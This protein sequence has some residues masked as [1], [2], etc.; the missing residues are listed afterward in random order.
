MRTIA[1]PILLL[2][3]ILLAVFATAALGLNLYLQS[4]G[5]RTLL[6]RELSGM[7][8][9][10]VSIH[11]ILGLPVLGIRLN[12]VTAGEDP[13]HPFLSVESITLHPDYLNLL[14]GRLVIEKIQLN[15][16]VV[17]LTLGKNPEIPSSTAVGS[18]GTVA[19]SI[20]SVGE[21]PPPSAP[22]SSPS[23]TIHSQA[24]SPY[25]DFLRS[26]SISNGEFT[27]L[28]ENGTRAISLTGIDLNA[29]PHPIEG[30][31]GT[32]QATQSVLADHLIIH[33]ISSSLRLSR[34]FSKLEC[35]PIQATLGGGA[36]KGTATF[37]WNPTQP[38]YSVSLKLDQATIPKLLT[39]ATFAP[40]SAEGKVSGNLNLSGIAG[41]GASMQGN[42][43]LLCTDAVIQPV[44]FLKQIGQ[45]LSIEELQVLRLAEGKCIF[46]ID[47]GHVLIDDLFLRSE[48][49]I[50]SAKGPL[51]PS[52]ELDLDSRLLFN[53]KLTGRL[54]GLLGSQL[55]P[56]PEQG[57]S[58]V[59][60]HVSGSPLNPK[61]DLLQRL[62]GLRIGGD[63]GGLLQGLFGRPANH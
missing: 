62:T 17:H 21:T 32:V 20:P 52:G 35:E 6:N 59:A 34:D 7:T 26:L 51:H 22:P 3:V 19:Q 44:D 12:G 38:A 9:T 56:A 39:D 53:T 23:V 18:F 57:Y 58:Q 24:I 1:K 41:Q 43:S 5:G 36:L 47:A 60:F 25:G 31:H 15:H 46:H 40:S 27:L 16:P 11:G 50:L 48:N 13:S 33:R 2:V 55:S 14:H 8:G 54:R 42:G 4:Q 37:T 45:L 10:P 63:L 29:S 30:W 49:L 61:T 28:N